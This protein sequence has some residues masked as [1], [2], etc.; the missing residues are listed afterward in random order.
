METAS[1]APPL[2]ELDTYQD[3]LEAFRP[4]LRDALTQSSYSAGASVFADTLISLDG[5]PHHKR[6]RLEM[7]LFTKSL[8]LTYEGELFPRLTSA[9]LAEI[10]TAGRANLVELAHIV[11]IQFAAQV[12]GLEGFEGSENARELFGLMMRLNE[13]ATLHLSTRPRE[14]VLEDVAEA[15]REFDRRFMDPALERRRAAVRDGEPLEPTDVLAILARAETDPDSDLDDAVIRREAYLYLI[16][17]AHTSAT[18]LVHAF[19]E[20]NAWLEAHPADHARTGDRDFL[21]QIVFETLRLHPSSPTQSRHAE[22]ELTLS[23]GRILPAGAEVVLNMVAANRDRE[24]FGENAEEFI[25]GRT[26]PD[27]VAPYGLSFGS[28]AHACIGRDLAAGSSR[29]VR[30]T[31]AEDADRSFGTVVQML[32]ALLEQ[33][34]RPDAHD[35]PLRSTKTKRELYTSFPILLGD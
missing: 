9:A 32:A 19:A 35:P 4:S 31:G 28:G 24:V 23:S 17:A 13:G 34:A 16:A 18:A 30:A 6:R 5:P 3:V 33:G 2:I 29:P 15:M 10:S 22:K 1:A 21:Q 27:G 8:F 7:P 20:L 11:T 25:P 26:L 14:E 12:T